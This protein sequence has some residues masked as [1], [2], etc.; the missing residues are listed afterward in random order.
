MS[1]R[2]PA[3]SSLFLRLSFHTIVLHVLFLLL[4]LLPLIVTHSLIPDAAFSLFACSSLRLKDSRDRNKNNVLCSQNFSITLCNS[5]SSQKKE[6]VQLKTSE[7]VW[8]L[9]QAVLTILCRQKR[10]Q[11]KWR[12]MDARVVGKTY[13]NCLKPHTSSHTHIQTADRRRREKRGSLFFHRSK[14]LL[15]LREIR[16]EGNVRRRERVVLRESKV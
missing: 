3:S 11:A 15:D 16:S 9:K 13:H 2:I 1:T 7:T 4:L 10:W 6:R 12:W 5:S 14:N 8:F